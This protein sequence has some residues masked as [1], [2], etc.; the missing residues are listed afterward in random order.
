MPWNS[1]PGRTEAGF[2]SDKVELEVKTCCD[3]ADRGLLENVF[4]LL[5]H[6]TFPLDI[7]FF[8]H[9]L[10][11][12]DSLKLPHQPIASNTVGWCEAVSTPVLSG[13]PTMH[14]IYQ[15][16][17][18][19][20]SGPATG[21]TW[22]ALRFLWRS[23]KNRRAVCFLFYTSLSLAILIFF[24]VPDTCARDFSCAAVCHYVQNW[25]FSLLILMAR[26]QN[27]PVFSPHLFK[28]SSPRLC[29]L[30]SSL[31]ISFFAAF[32]HKTFFFLLR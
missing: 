24:V 11:A 7:R 22:A 8:N 25:F 14:K 27:F 17:A 19:K 15:E 21:N 26:V 6:M 5:T 18:R 28:L 1:R 32:F 20:I 31:S 29:T 12:H 10:F 4:S 9:K 16:I 13:A 23:N 30:T 2:T 3:K